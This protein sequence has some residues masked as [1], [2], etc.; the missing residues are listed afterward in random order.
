MKKDLTE[1]RIGI[2]KRTLEKR[3]FSYAHTFDP[4]ERFKTDIK[5]LR[6][7]KSIPKKYDVT[8]LE[9]IG[10]RR[11]YSKCKTRFQNEKQED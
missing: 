9:I 5:G 7:L 2:I 3:A 8:T 11:F 4:Y 10:F 1:K 6:Y